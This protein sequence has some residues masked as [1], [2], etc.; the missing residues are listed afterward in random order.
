MAGPKRSTTFGWV[1]RELRSMLPQWFNILFLGERDARSFVLSAG[2]TSITG[3]DRRLIGPLTLWTSNAEAQDLGQHRS[4]S[5]I[6]EIPKDLCLSRRIEVPARGASQV[7]SIAA[8]DLA[9]KTPFR[10]DDVYTALSPPEPGGDGFLVTQWVIRRADVARLERNLKGHGMALR[11]V[12]IAGT[13]TSPPLIADLSAHNDRHAA[14]WRRINASLVSA[15][16]VAAAIGWLYP[17]V[18]TARSLA[19]LDARLQL[20]QEEAVRLRGEVEARRTLAGAEAD[21]LSTVLL[22]QHLATTLRE[23]TVALDDNAWL[24]DLS[25]SRTGVTF[26]G[27]TATSAAD[28][29]IGLADSRSFENPRLSGPVSRSS[30]G[31]ERFEIALDFRGTE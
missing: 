1:L 16:L 23:L 22:R 26:S 21:F 11:G 2:A 13:S 3:N 17:A 9:R 29:L 6:A 10:A 27:E 14:V 8:L 31:S 12:R 28:L 24:T 30:T 7:A 18:Q 5:I 25:F 4:R 15:G 20:A 19:A